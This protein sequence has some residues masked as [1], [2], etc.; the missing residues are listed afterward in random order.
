[1]H[2]AGNPVKSRFFLLTDVSVAFKIDDVTFPA[3]YPVD[4]DVASYIT[5]EC[6]YAFPDVFICPWSEGDL[7]SQMVE[8]W[9]HAITLG[10]DGYAG[11]FS[12]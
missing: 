7:V 9:V 6:Y 2:D 5:D 12:N 10:C 11:T 4:E 3:Y 1:M 8:K